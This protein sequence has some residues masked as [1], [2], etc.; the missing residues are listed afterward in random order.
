MVP[1]PLCGLTGPTIV[2]S[3]RLSKFSMCTLILSSYAC[4]PSLVSSNYFYTPLSLWLC[5]SHYA[6][7]DVAISPVWVYN[8]A[9][10]SSIL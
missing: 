4:I 2:D 9:I 10:S 5:S 6:T 7:K 1:R 8:T 3:D